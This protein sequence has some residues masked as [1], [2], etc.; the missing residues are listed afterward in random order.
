MKKRILALACTAALL[1]FGSEAFAAAEG[2]ATARIGSALSVSKLATGSATGG[3]LAFGYIIPNALT[4]GTVKVNNNGN[5]TY[6][7]V[8]GTSFLPVGAAQFQV[9]GYAGASYNVTLSNSATI[10]SGSNT[11]T[12]G[13]FT[14]N[15]TGVLTGGSEIFNVGGTLTVGAGQAP[16]E[17]TGPFDVTV[18]Y[19]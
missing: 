14:K 6:T 11:M 7:G 1:A 5:P 19:Q 10:T 15:E 9:T 13:S 17:Y 4:A 8:T 12:V 2:T 3:D 18:A 16:G